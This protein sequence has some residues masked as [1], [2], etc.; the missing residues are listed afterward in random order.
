MAFQP[1]SSERR[2]LCVS[3][4]RWC[5]VGWPFAFD[6]AAWYLDPCGSCEFFFMHQL[7]GQYTCSSVEPYMTTDHKIALEFADFGNPLRCCLEFFSDDLVQHQLIF[8]AELCGY[9][10]SKTKARKSLLELLALHVGDDEFAAKVVDR[11]PKCRKSTATASGSDETRDDDDIQDEL[12]ELI[13]ESMDKDEIGDFKDILQRVSS[14]E[15]MKKKL[16]WQKLFEKH[17]KAAWLFYCPY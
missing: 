16:K 4:L 3:N 17:M 5:I 10:V 9:Q 13:L 1:A 15:K 14:K 8:L 7:D 2:F 12:A 6:D 11:D